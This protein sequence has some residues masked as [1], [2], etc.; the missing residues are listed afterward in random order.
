MRTV[1]EDP[2][3]VP[4]DP[5]SD[6]LIAQNGVAVTADARVLSDSFC[7]GCSGFR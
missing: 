7:G 5:G 4:A 1:H 6:N 3:A 2:L